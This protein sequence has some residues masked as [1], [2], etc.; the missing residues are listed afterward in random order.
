MKEGFIKIS[1]KLFKNWIYPTNQN[2]KLTE[3]EAWIEILR[4]ANFVCVEKKIQDK[5]VVVPRGYFDTTVSQLSNIFQWNARTTEKFLKLLESQKMISRYKISKSLK[6]CTLLKINNYNDYQAEVY[7]VCNS[8][9]KTKCHL[10][11]KN[12]EKN[13]PKKEETPKK[14]PKPK[15]EKASK[16]IHG[17]YKNVSL[18]DKELER[19]I[20]EYGKDGANKL[21]EFLSAYKKEKNYRTKDDNLTIRRWVIDACKLPKKV[22]NS[23]S[24]DYGGF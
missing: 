10:N 14:E 12:C 21:I 23:L 24:E 9:Y 7:E 4:L 15:K 19:F 20:D 5:F 1:R 11:C 6:S 16:H 22:S 13:L 17:E 2:R 3:F 18:T 8:E